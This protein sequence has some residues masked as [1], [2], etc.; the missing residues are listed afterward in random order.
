MENHV[1]LYL[2]K[3]CRFNRQLI[4]FLFSVLS[5]LRNLPFLLPFTVISVLWDFIKNGCNENIQSD[6][7]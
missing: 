3:F 2:G 1:L 6:Q 4:G 5:I 7:R